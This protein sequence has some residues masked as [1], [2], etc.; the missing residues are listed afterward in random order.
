[1]MKPLVVA[2]L[3]VVLFAGPGFAVNLRVPEDFPEIQAALDAAAEGEEVLVGPGEYVVSRPVAFGRKGIALRS[4]EGAARTTIR[5]SETPE[6]PRR[7]SVVLIEGGGA[8]PVLLEGFTLTGGQGSVLRDGD[9]AR[10][11]GGIRCLPGAQVSVASCVIIANRAEGGGGLSASSSQLDMRDCEVSSNWARDSGGG[12]AVSGPDVR[13]ARTTI[14]G[15]ASSA[16]GG[17]SIGGGSLQLSQCRVLANLSYSGGGLF[18]REGAS[19]E[20]RNCAFAG[21]YTRKT[22]D[23]IGWGG[24]M[25]LT[26]SG[27]VFPL[28]NCTVTENGAESGSGAGIWVEWGQQPVV[29]PVQNGPVTITNSFVWGNSGGD[30]ATRY[31]QPFQVTYSSVG[32]DIRNIAVRSWHNL[33]VTDPLFVSP[34]VFDFTS[35]RTVTI[36][37]QEVELPDFIVDP[38][39]YRLRGDSPLVDRGTDRGA[40]AVDLDG[41]ARPCGQGVDIGAYET[42]DCRPAG[43]FL[44]GDTDADARRTISDAV[45]TLLHLFLGGNGPSCADAADA[46]DNGLLNL[47]D[48]IYLLNRLFR[49]GPPPPAPEGDCGPD[50]TA[51]ELDCASHPPCG[52]P[53]G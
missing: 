44:R 28:W 18:M 19:L 33:K 29:G 4:R 2:L 51:D 39:D 8:V 20:A 7:A 45:F 14:A 12:L 25:F 40:P 43:L 11:G 17:L 27:N 48:P 16:G 31:G 26:T 53:G 50:P 32:H 38:G 47:A 23:G 6:D 5:M 1:M 15:N 41:H 24:A 37:G 10:Y 35:F 22:Q 49:G 46:D 34:G 42:G 30:L 3:L 21:N 9:S 36:A 13:I 52:G